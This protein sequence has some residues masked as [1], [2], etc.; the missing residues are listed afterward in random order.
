MAK[1][2]FQHYFARVSEA[3]QSSTDSLAREL[4]SN[5]LIGLEV[6]N[7]VLTTPGLSSTR[8][9]SSL[10]CAVAGK[11]E[12]ANNGNPFNSFCQVLKS[13]REVESLAMEMTKRFGKCTVW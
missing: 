7:D 12:T 3:I 5:K 10:M 8:K 9:S 6:M 11:I 13:F 2:V 4:F 1:R